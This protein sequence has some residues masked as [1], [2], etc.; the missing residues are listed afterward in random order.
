MIAMHFE[1]KYISK[2]FLTGETKLPGQCNLVHELEDISFLFNNFFAH[3]LCP[4]VKKKD[5][6]LATIVPLNA[7]EFARYGTI[8]FMLH[9]RPP[10]PR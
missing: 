10:C 3:T 4:A 6:L 8:S 5:L 9:T 7:K 2:I 1:D